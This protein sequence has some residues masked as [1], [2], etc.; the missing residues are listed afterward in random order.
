MMATEPNRVM[1]RNKVIHYDAPYRDK[2]LP[3]ARHA[4]TLTGSY[5]GFHSIPSANRLQQHGLDPNAEPVIHKYLV[6]LAA[7]VD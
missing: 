5:L 4:V 3:L 1:D 7:A 2:T 6:Q